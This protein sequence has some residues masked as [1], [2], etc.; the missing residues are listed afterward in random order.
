VIW[1]DQ[2]GAGK[3]T[4]PT[5]VKSYTFADYVADLDAVR[6][7]FGV[8]KLHVFGHSWGGAVTMAYAIA[9][10]EH[11]A[12]VILVDNEPPSQT[13][14]DEGQA[15]LSARIAELQK[16]GKIPPDPLPGPKG[17]DCMAFSEAIWPA[18][19]YDPSLKP[20]PDIAGET[21]SCTANLNT[22]RD[23]TGFD[24][25][26]D[27]AKITAPTLS[28]FGAQDAFGLDWQDKTVAALTGTK[29]VK[30]VVDKSGHFPWIEQP[31]AWADAFEGFL[32]SV[33]AK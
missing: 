14:L 9:H 7:A 32:A 3:S 8:D 28:V 15:R 29:P 23:V 30:V 1:Y 25:T 21:N 11:V 12:S 20:P 19:L 31:K 2:R 18:Y 24:M 4:R 5:S 13:L 6:A 17:N 16:E 10:P 22:V 27:L 33:G 26:A